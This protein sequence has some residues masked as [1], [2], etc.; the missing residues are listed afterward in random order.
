M[1]TIHER[2]PF[3]GFAIVALLLPVIGLNAGLIAHISF[4]HLAGTRRR[5][6]CQRMDIHDL[7]DHPA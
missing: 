7:Q 4:S 2:I 3:L 1:T 6:H 5:I